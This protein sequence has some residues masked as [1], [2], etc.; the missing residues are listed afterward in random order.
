ML[1]RFRKANVLSKKKLGHIY[2]TAM[3]A[4][5]KEPVIIKAIAGGFSDECKKLVEE[6]FEYL[7]AVISTGKFYKTPRKLKKRICK[8]I[9]ARF[10]LCVIDVLIADIVFDWTFLKP[11]IERDDGKKESNEVDESTQQ[12]LAQAEVSPE[13]YY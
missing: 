12:A 11:L 9:S 1:G 6:R 8:D 3:K 2:D 7:E 5:G 4:V 10:N 13:I